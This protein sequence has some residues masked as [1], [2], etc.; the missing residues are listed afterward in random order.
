MISRKEGGKKEDRN[1]KLK[2]RVDTTIFERRENMKNYYT[3]HLQRR[4]HA[5]ETNGISFSFFFSTVHLILDN[6][7]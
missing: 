4:K 1:A 6:L 7:R 2:D 3:I 5:E